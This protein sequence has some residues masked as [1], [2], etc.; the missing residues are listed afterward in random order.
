MIIIDKHAAPI[1]A[2]T[3]IFCCLNISAFVSL[4]LFSVK[5][6]MLLPSE[7]MS[8]PA[9][10]SIIG[11]LISSVSCIVSS[12]TSWVNPLILYKMNKEKNETDR[13][14]LNKRNN[15]WKTFDRP[16]PGLSY[17]YYIYLWHAQSRKDCVPRWDALLRMPLKPAN[18]KQN[19]NN[20]LRFKR[21]SWL[22]FWCYCLSM[23][24]DNTIPSRLGP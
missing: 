17:I 13:E 19:C 12:W 7:S 5:I 4:I 22:M 20:S 14:T 15:E 23:V 2:Q 16:A 6:L 18:R 21:N 11:N 3:V 8:D 24:Y 1:E 9:L 10:I